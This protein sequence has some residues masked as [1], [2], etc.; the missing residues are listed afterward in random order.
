MSS[1]MRIILYSFMTLTE[2]MGKI[3]KLSNKERAM[4]INKDL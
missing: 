2:L 3:S 4:L 1:G